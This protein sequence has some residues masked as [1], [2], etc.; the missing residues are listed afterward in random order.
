[1]YIN[2]GNLEE[3]QVFA[4][5]ELDVT[6]CNYIFIQN[7]GSVAAFLGNR[8]IDAGK[9]IEIPLQ[10]LIQEKIFNIRF[11]TGVV[12]DKSLYIMLGKVF[13]KCTNS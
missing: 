12:G 2:K 1:M 9:E 13:Y 3:I 5:Q 7:N 10:F 4:D 8:K 6:N 11:E